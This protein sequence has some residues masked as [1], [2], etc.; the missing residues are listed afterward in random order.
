MDFSLISNIAIS[1]L[2]LTVLELV[3]GVDNLIFIAI[4]SSRLPAEKQKPARRFGLMLALVTRLL[5]LAMAFW[6]AHLTEPLFHLASFAV[7]GRDIFLFIGGMFLLYKA[8]Q[9]I[10]TELEDEEETTAKKKTVSMASVITQIAI[11]DI[12]FSLDSVITAVGMTPHFWVM[13]AAITIAIIGMIFVSEPLSQFIYRHPTVKMLA[14][15]FLLLV[16]TVLVADGMHF[17]IPRGYVYFAVSFSI[18]VEGLNI[19]RQKKRK[20]VS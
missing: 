12:V 8:T 16:G 2:T 7:S 9:E 13:A 3:L 18:L 1:L 11:L 14:F 15:S 19:W 4:V 5:L 20:K 17:H 6:L 10:H